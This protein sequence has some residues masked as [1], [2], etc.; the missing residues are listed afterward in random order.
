MRL[1]QIFTVLT[2]SSLIGGKKRQLSHLNIKSFN[3]LSF[4]IKW[5]GLEEKDQVDILGI[6]SEAIDESVK[7]EN[8]RW[9][10]V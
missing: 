9:V 2:I 5:V 10:W 4:E 6:R 1:W 3:S 7:S 8:G